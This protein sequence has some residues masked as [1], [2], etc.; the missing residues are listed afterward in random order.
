MPAHLAF[1]TSGAHLAP[2]INLWPEYHTEEGG[3]L[4]HFNMRENWKGA[5]SNYAVSKLLVQY[6]FMEM[7]E[8]A[9][10][11]D[12][13]YVLYISVSQ[14]A[15]SNTHTKAIGHLQQPLSRTNCHRAGPVDVR[16]FCYLSHSVACH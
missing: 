2:N 7:A 15:F 1:V 14:H 11:P 3:I 6:A 10:G 13:K 5:I 16:I 9:L 12:K 4:G 8:M